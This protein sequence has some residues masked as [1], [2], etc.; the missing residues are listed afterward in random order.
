MMKLLSTITSV[1]QGT[2]HRNV[3]V[4]CVCVELVIGRQQVMQ[5]DETKVV[6]SLIVI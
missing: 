3:T 4:Y 1:K 6:V 2:K 5:Q